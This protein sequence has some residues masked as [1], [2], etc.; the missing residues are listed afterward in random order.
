[1]NR[2]SKM[3]FGLMI[4]AF[5]AAPSYSAD[6]LVPQE[7]A[8]ELM[9]LRQPSVQKEL[10]LTSEVTE[11]VH[12]YCA[13]QWEKAQKVSQL[14]EKEQDKEFTT[15]AKENHRFV[16]ETL[17]KEQ[18][19]RLHQITLQ[20]AGLLC[21][22]RHDIASHLKLTE[23]QK[24]RLPEL[25]KEAHQEIEELLYVMKKEQRQEKMREL[26]E[27][28]RK[29][30]LELLTDEQEVAWKEMIGAPFLGDL[31]YVDPDTAGK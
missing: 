1:M 24:K 16:D 14:S 22:T 30:L 10:K 20:T 7:G 21:V 27:T 5:W 26:R 18:S 28:N 23:D 29:R 31:A 13:Q 3:A 6:K 12:K 4:L 19:K 2:F 11:K 17:T 9:L 15:M 8:L 25:H